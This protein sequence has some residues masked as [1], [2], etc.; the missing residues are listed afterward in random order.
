[1]SYHGNEHYNS[2][3]ELHHLDDNEELKQ[4]QG[5]LHPKPGFLEQRALE[6]S[7]LRSIRKH[8]SHPSS[9]QDEILDAI[10]SSRKEFETNG[11]RD[12]EVALT[13]SMQDYEKIAEE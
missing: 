10:L 3:S 9:P 7:R 6:N 11:K 12:M 2:I 13:E 8:E 5:S 1:L 4:S